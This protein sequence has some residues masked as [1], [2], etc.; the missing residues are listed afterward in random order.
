ML[1]V[2]ASSPHLQPINSVALVMRRVMLALIP[3]VAACLW[4][5]GWG[6]LVNLALA[7]ATALTAEAVMLR[8]R[9]RPL[10]L[11]LSDGSAVVT[12]LLL[13]LALPA[14]APWWLTV[15]A[16][17]FAV[18]VAKHLYGGLGYNPF[19]PAMVGY[20]VALISFPLPMT[21]WV[22][23]DA[24][25]HLD[26]LQ[27]LAYQ[28]RGVLPG[29]LSVDAVTAATPLDAIKTQIELRRTLSEIREGG[30]AFGAF[31]GVGW[32]WAGLAFLAGGLWLLYKGVIHWHI[33][34][35]MLGGLAGMA[36]LFYLFDSDTYA[37]P[38]LHLFSGGAMLGA[39]FIATDPVT[40]STTDRGRL[41]YGAGIGVLT[42]LIR[43]WGGYPDG[44]AFAVLL[45]NMAAPTIDHYTQPRVFG[46]PGDRRGG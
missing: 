46:A 21:L 11:F 31:G 12:A 13:A 3:G 32:E 14:L 36:L 39:F 34:A 40:A 35:G 6:V 4:L 18:V 19:N 17:G 15:L 44:V 23:P 8:L 26:L 16:T 29:D 45:M 41:I 1:F 7:T 27:T 5:F 33:P 37:S 10:G 38:M 24:A 22:T 28:L 2:R 43:T 25:V 42:Y 9:G 30:G 20:V